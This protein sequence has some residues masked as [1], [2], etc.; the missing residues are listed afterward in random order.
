MNHG[1]IDGRFRIGHVIGKGN[2]GEVHRAEDLHADE[3][4]PSAQSP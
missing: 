3:G 1:L 4:V 2:M